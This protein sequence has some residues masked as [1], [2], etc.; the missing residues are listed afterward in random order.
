MRYILLDEDGIPLR[1]FWS[2]EDAEK[3]KESNYTIKVLPK[4]KMKRKKVTRVDFIKLFGEPP[5]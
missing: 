2:A 1:K 3:H 5:F 4:P